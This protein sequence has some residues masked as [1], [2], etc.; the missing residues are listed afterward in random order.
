[1]CLIKRDE[2][3]DKIELDLY[4]AVTDYVTL[5]YEIASCQ[6]N[7]TLMFLLLIYQRMV[8]SSSRAIYK[9]LSK[10]LMV[11][12]DIQRN[13]I[14]AGRDEPDD[15]NWE[16]LE[17]LPAEEQLIE[18]QRLANSMLPQAQADSLMSEITALRNCVSLAQRASLGR[19]DVKFI[20]LL[21][22]VDEFKIR[23]NNPKLKFIIFT[24]FVETQVYLRDCLNNLGYAT[25]LIHGQMSS[26]DRIIQLERFRDEAQFLIS[27]DAGG[28]GINL[29]FCWV[30]IHYDLPWNPMR[31]EQR[32]GRID[33][34]GQEHDVK[35]VNFQLADTVEERVRNVLESKLATIRR[36]FSNGEDKL[37]DILSTLQDEFNFEKI[38]MDALVKRRQDAA[39]LEETA[40][41]IFDRAKAII[42]EE[43][44]ALPFSNLGEKYNV[45]QHDI[46]KRSLKAKQLTELYLQAYGSTLNQYK[47]KTGFYYFQDPRTGKHMQNV[48]FQQKYSLDMENCELLSFNNPF[49][50]DL[51]SSLADELQVDT[52]AKLLVKEEKFKGDKGF[53]FIHRLKVTNYI[54]P[55]DYYLLPCFVS[56][57]TGTGL[58]NSRIAKYFHDFNRISCSDLVIGEIPYDIDH[59]RHLA[60]DAVRQRAE[61]V[62]Y[63]VKGRIADKL[64]EEEVKFEKFYM[65]K[66]TAIMRIAVENIRNAKMRELAD[67][68]SAK[69]RERERRRQVVP[70]LNL[71]QIAYVEFV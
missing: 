56:F 45:S 54:D 52:T 40:R 2:E 69:R 25:T 47:H 22:I 32:N 50:M 62:F 15:V 58:V 23:E 44:L 30:M 51:M 21:E 59:A 38:Y 18:L 35:V 14:Q 70:S 10:R 37:A 17:D 46:D 20:K 5:F 13:I 29:Q 16:H 28:E 39:A 65:D 43:Q 19:N 67:E 26:E 27:T 55:Y 12:E 3:K 11:L 33:R 60:D 61:T 31:L 4:Q 1:M 7:R 6:N 42:E 68:R 64:Q 53:L 24:E 36:E 63:E 49:I 9:S 48:I 57:A 8:S 41:Q 71:E 34:I 66:E